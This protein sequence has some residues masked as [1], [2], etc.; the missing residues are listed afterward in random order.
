M[1]LDASLGAGSGFGVGVLSESAGFI[2]KGVGVSLTEE[3]GW[4]K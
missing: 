4:L 2:E 3:R 1:S